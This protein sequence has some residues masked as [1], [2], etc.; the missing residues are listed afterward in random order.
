MER[1]SVIVVLTFC[2]TT[3]SLATHESAILANLGPEMTNSTMLT[4]MKMMMMMMMVVGVLNVAVP[5]S[6]PPSENLTIPRILGCQDP[7]CRFDESSP[8]LEYQVFFVLQ[9]TEDS[10]E[11][12]LLL[13]IQGACTMVPLACSSR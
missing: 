8:L 11:L 2:P 13:C 9:H 7:M 12:W 5:Q 10:Q 3:F 6:T 1:E 4:S